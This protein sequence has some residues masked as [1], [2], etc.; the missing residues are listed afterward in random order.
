MDPYQARPSPQPDHQ[1]SHRISNLSDITDYDTYDGYHED[2]QDSPPLRG[3]PSLVSLQSAA[4]AASP[5]YDPSPP[6]SDLSSASLSSTWS[7]PFS[8]YHA[9]AANAYEPV[10]AS[11]GQTPT[12][13]RSRTFARR[14]SL[15]NTHATIAEEPEDIRES[16]DMATLVTHMAPMGTSK[17][18]ASTYSPI[19]KDDDAEEPLP[20]MPFDVTGF[21]GPATTQDEA[22]TKILQEQEASGKLT[23]GLGVGFGAGT[24]LKE[25]DLLA[26][27]PAADRGG[28]TRSFTRRASVMRQGTVKALAQSEANKR[29]VIVEVIM[30][31]PVGAVGSEVDLSVMAG[32][33]SV[34]SGEPHAVRRSTL[35]TAGQR[36]ERFFPQPN[37]R[38]FSMRWPYLLMLIGL[39]VGL[40][41]L[42]EVL[43]R[44]GSHDPLLT[45][46]SPSQI[47]TAQYFAFKFAPT[48]ISV[49]F[50]VLWQ[51]TDMD[52]KRL[53][54]FYQLSKERGAL[55]DES[56]NVDYITN[57]NLLGPIRA[58]HCKHYAV[59][60]SSVASLLAVSLVPTLG[61]AAIMLTPD[62]T[63]RLANPGGDKSI[64]VSQI[65]SRL[66]TATLC[67]IACL[68]CVLFWQL[69]SR[70]SGLMADVKG[71]AGLA[72]MA[73][74]SHILMDFKDMDV[75]T[76]QDIHLKLK[77]HRYV[78]RNNSLASYDELPVTK[79]E[80]DRYKENHLSQNPHPLMLRA[81]GMAPFIVGIGL[82]AC[83][84]PIFLFTG[85]NV[86]TDKAPW[87]ATALAVCIKLSWGSLDTSVRIM[88]PYYILSR[89]HAPPKMLTLDY[90]GMPFG[91][92]AVQALFNRHAIVFLV[93]VG[94]VLADLLTVLV[95]ALAS[96]EGRAF[97]TAIDPSA[98]PGPDSH[99]IN[100]GEETPVSFW[101]SLGLVIF[102]LLYLATMATVVFVR[103]RR[104]FLPRQPNTIAS[105]LA[106]IHQ[107][108]ML[109]DFVGTSKFSNAEM[110]GKLEG[111]EKTYGLGWFKGRDGQTHCGV[112]QEEL[113]SSYKLGYDYSRSNKPWVDRPVEWL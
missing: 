76:H 101:V 81:A 111:L 112:D 85:A 1:L 42:Q 98:A 65:W 53:E 31:E 102:I 19:P 70:R 55:A 37:W 110:V 26:I 66:L 32:S 39:S 40:A 25:S 109:Y 54:A 34:G 105:V 72:S 43:Y 94:T 78:L 24:K 100:S 79:Q 99:Q 28:V 107:S 91:W 21:M 23:G 96:V 45:F 95:T 77:D 90:T 33:A 108:K 44:L 3:R 58:L 41:V 4:A 13:Q 84:V 93:C 27:S 5:A 9:G 80:V 18:G 75:A 59:A 35:P 68:G 48:I 16:I 38:P 104:P 61:T 92:V 57:F 106:F 12:H 46:Q 49:T 51:I 88:E 52:V 10:P 11:G 97:I 30:E 29:G 73:V 20:A 47:P 15:R 56:I 87:V 22:F 64:M 113:M 74:V 2:P 17:M 103:R 60:V 86:V 6:L 67:V 89:R 82:F 7:A 63:T 83:L 71:I 50:G 69:Q 8:G 62:R 36:T 14:A